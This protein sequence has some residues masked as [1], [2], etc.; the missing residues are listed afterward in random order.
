MKKIVPYGLLASFSLFLFSCGSD[1][2]SFLSKV[3]EHVDPDPII[4]KTYYL[5]KIDQRYY[6][7]PDTSSPNTEQ[8][9]LQH[10]TYSFFYDE[11]FTLN[12]AV[13]HNIISEDGSTPQTFSYKIAHT[14]N[15]QKQLQKIA[16]QEH[17]IDASSY[18]YF[19]NES[20]VIKCISRYAGQG[21][22][23]G[24]YKYNNQKQLIS[25]SA[26]EPRLF[27]N[28]SYNNLNQISQFTFYGE[29]FS[30]TYDNKKNPFYNLPYDLTSI[31][32]GFDL[33]FPYTYQFPN[34]ITSLVIDKKETTIEYAYNEENLPIR[35]TSYLGQK[36]DQKIIYDITYT[37]EIKETEVPLN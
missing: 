30:M 21:S 34:N 16:F 31:I 11:I 4:E 33:A 28:Y 36:E 26:P 2:H 22:F 5:S 19:Y 32:L 24:D 29:N 7:T 25:Y 14:L 37:Y 18:K 9:I 8:N 1:D 13:F 35:A 15:E 12:H 27:A 17:E 20:L 6:S 10:I 3:P 23:S